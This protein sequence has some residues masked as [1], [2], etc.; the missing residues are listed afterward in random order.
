MGDF[1]QG[2]SLATPNRRLLIDCI[3]VIYDEMCEVENDDHDDEHG[4][5]GLENNESYYGENPDGKEDDMKH[6]VKE[7]ANNEE[8]FCF[9]K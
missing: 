4:E 8:Y 9:I 6:E 2:F 3:N 1:L 5:H 7:N